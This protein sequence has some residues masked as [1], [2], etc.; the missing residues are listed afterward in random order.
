MTVRP[1]GPA[2]LEQVWRDS[3]LAFGYRTDTPPAS[4]QGWYGLDGPGGRLRA[5]ARVRSY[6]Q[7]WGGRRVEMAG[8]ASVVVPPE[9]RGQGA[10]GALLRELLPVLR[11]SGQPLSVLFP[12]AVGVYRPHGWEVVGSL[13]DTRIATRDLLPRGGTGAV[14][15]RTATAADLPALGELYAGCASAGWLTRDGPEFPAGPAVLLQHDVVA[16]AVG[17]DDGAD[18]YAAYT[19]GAGYRE[20]SELRVWECVGRTGTATAALLTS[21]ASWSTVAATVLWRGPTREL[22]LFLPRAVPPPVCSQPWMLRIV[23]APGA[24]AQRGFRPEVTIEAGFVLVDPAV[25]EHERGWQLQVA[26]GRGTL[27]PLPTADRQPALHVR[28]LA[29]LYAGAADTSTLLRAGLLD[30]PLPAL[31]AA[32]AGPPPVLLDYF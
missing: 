20:G 2:D 28:G 19:R 13:D 7:W 6:R 10:A 9:A 30:R 27:Q 12:T 17:D 18:G 23:D 1:L 22:A 15:I 32:F 5:F 16:L 8:I 4:A 29:L 14:R 25:P 24:I 21:L 26:A 31:D 3:Q 11:G